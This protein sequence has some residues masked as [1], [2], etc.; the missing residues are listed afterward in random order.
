MYEAHLEHLAEVFEALSRYG[1][2]L[3]PSKCHLLKPKVQYLGHVVSA[4]G[5]AL[6]P[7]KITAIQNW[8]RP[9]TVREVRQ[10]LGLMGYYRMFAKGYTKMAAPLKDL[11]VW[12]P[13]Y[14]KPSGP[15]FKWG[16]QQED[17]FEQMKSALTGEEILAYPEGQ[18]EGNCLCKAGS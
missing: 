8:P 18:R 13:T 1:M 6:D 14:S 9:S 3:K 17:S 10:F 12:Q 5:V 16:K 4:E 2:K 7:E 15:P 11:L